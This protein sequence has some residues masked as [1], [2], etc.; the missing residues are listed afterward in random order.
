MD[1]SCLCL[2]TRGLT[3]WAL[4]AVFLVV[5]WL[6]REANFSPPSSAKVQNR[7]V[8]PPLSIRLRGVV[9]N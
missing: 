4:G 5:K 7:G 1:V 3:Q 8:V 9:L 2:C 6:G